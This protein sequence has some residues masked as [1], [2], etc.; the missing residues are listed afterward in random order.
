MTIT[1][2]I[3]RFSRPNRVNFTASYH[4]KKY[5]RRIRQLTCHVCL[6][7]GQSGRHHRRRQTG[8]QVLL[9]LP[10]DHVQGAFAVVVLVLGA[11][12]QRG[13]LGRASGGGH[14]A[15][16]HAVNAGRGGRGHSGRRS[17]VRFFRG[18]R[19]VGSVRD[20]GPAADAT[21]GGCGRGCRGSAPAGRRGRDGG[22][23]V[24]EQA[25]GPA[26]GLPVI[27]RVDHEQRLDL[28]AYRRF[29]RAGHFVLDATVDVQGH[30]EVLDAV[31]GRPAAGPGRSGTGRRRTARGSG[32]SGHHQGGRHAGGGGQRARVRGPVARDHRLV[33]TRSGV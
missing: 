18:R 33:V 31:P 20:G 26:L 23:V 6:V 29:G 3:N 13:P 28:A 27:R 4:D 25:A 16:D 8:L 10:L 5:R 15:G 32:G 17:G 19:S 24:D 11:G 14:G 21:G 2:T 30:V 7:G 1:S 12:A 9:V 22:H